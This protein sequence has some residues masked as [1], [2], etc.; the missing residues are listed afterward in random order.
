VT[1]AP[2]PRPV[3]STTGVPHV[4]SDGRTPWVVDP[5]AYGPVGDDE[6]DE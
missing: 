1:P 2:P 4:W 6:G 5:R 3:V